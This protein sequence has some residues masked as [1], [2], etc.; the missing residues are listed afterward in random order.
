MPNWAPL[1]PIALLALI[2]PFAL[3]VRWQVRKIN[4]ED[5]DGLG[6]PRLDVSGF[7]VKSST[8][9]SSAKERE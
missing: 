7:D 5:P 9:G 4:R 3:W 8:D 1:V 6:S 2:V